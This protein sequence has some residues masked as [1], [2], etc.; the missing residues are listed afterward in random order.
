MEAQLA[1]DGVPDP[2]TVQSLIAELQKGPRLISAAPGIGKTHQVVQ[3][4]EE[5]D[6]VVNR[7][8][9]HAVPSHKSFANVERHGYWEHWQGHA[10]GMA[11]I[12][13]LS[14]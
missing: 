11:K 12:N 5:H 13:R 2:G 1:G 10:N 9:L 3:L 7:P 4:A 6:M 14:Q 8:V